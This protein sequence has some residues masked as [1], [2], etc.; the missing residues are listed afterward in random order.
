[1]KLFV[2]H[3]VLKKQEKLDAGCL[4]TFA[5]FSS[6]WC[7]FLKIL[8]W[9]TTNAGITATVKLG[10]KIAQSQTFISSEVVCSFSLHS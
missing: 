2:T 6:F 4:P 10:Q 8:V 5:F 9:N 1:M 7:V 3:I